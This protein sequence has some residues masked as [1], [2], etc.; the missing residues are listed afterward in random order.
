ME[1]MIAQR[2]AHDSATLGYYRV[3]H[4]YLYYFVVPFFFESKMGTET[5]F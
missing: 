2:G 3:L 5:R 1:L 4:I